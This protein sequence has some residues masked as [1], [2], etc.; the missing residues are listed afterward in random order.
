[1][2]NVF[3]QKESFRVTGIELGEKHVTISAYAS[4]KQDF[5]QAWNYRIL[6]FYLY[7][8]YMSK[9]SLINPFAFDINHLEHVFTKLCK[10]LETCRLKK[11]KN[12]E[13]GLQKAEIERK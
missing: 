13:K 7:M 4:Y 6:C 3:K 5:C 12:W 10:M 1:M 2:E 11:K 8:V 9:M